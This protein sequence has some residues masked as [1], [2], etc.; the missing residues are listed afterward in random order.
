MPSAR[1]ATL[2]VANNGVDSSICGVPGNP[3][4]SISQAISN[5]APGDTISVGPGRYGDVNNDGDFSDA[6]DE[7]AVSGSGC[8]C[9]INIDKPLTILSSSGASATVLDASGASITVVHIQTSNVVFGASKKGFTL[10]GADS[11]ENGLEVVSGTSNVKLAGNIAVGN[12]GAGF[13]FVGT[14]QDVRGNLAT[15]NNGRGFSFGGTNNVVVGNV[16]QANRQTGISFSGS[17]HTVQGNISEANGSNGISFDGTGHQITKNSLIGNV[18]LGIIVAAGGNA[19]ITGNNIYGNDSDATGG[20]TNCGLSNQSGLALTA[21]GNFW[22]LAVG[23]NIDPGDNVCDVGG[24][25][26]TTVVPFAT[27]EIKVKVKLAL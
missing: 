21:T 3:C 13:E 24:G 6:G 8:D 7:T 4:R 11:S 12:D 10:T 1:S 9:M 25:S 20:A 5:A 17:G 16:A 15:A 23:P 19:T 2:L 18:Q 22:G 26:V 27:K 14:G